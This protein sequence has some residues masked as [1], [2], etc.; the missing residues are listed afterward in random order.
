MGNQRTDEL[1]KNESEKSFNGPDPTRCVFYE[2]MIRTG[3]IILL[4]LGRDKMSRSWKWQT[5]EAYLQFATAFK[6][7]TCRE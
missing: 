6:L 2:T 7:I 1:A 3:K 4:T 5:K